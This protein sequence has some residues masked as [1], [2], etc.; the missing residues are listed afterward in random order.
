MLSDLRLLIKG[1]RDGG[2]I[3]II[4]IDY[5]DISCTAVYFHF[6]IILVIKNDEIVG[7]VLVPCDGNDLTAGYIPTFA[8][9]FKLC[10]DRVVVT[11]PKLDIRVAY[12]DIRNG[13]LLVIRHVDLGRAVLAL[14]V[15]T[16]GGIVCEKS[17]VVR[18]GEVNID[19][20]TILTACD[21]HG[22]IGYVVEEEGSVTLT[23]YTEVVDGFGDVSSVGNGS[24]L[25]GAL[26][27]L[28]LTPLY[29]PVAE[30]TELLREKNEMDY[31]A[32]LGE[33]LS[34]RA[35]LKA[36]SA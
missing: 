34:K 10:I 22:V 14:G 17:I 21:I 33:I 35:A 19:L 26:G 6:L 11:A 15:K 8:A 25:K 27:N 16:R 20:C 36:L 18:G 3:L 29:A 12:D 30:M 32:M 2:H 7:R 4:V 1:C 9:V 28:S 23:L 31:S 5:A 13:Y 24:M